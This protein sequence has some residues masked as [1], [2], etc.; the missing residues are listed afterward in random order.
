MKLLFKRDE[1]GTGFP[2]ADQVLVGELVMN[3]VTGKLYTKLT[4][5][6]IV[7]WV[8][9]KICFDPIPEITVSYENTVITSDI[10]EDY[11]CLGGIIEFEVA[12]LKPDPYKYTFEFV[13]LTTNTS[14]G[15]ISLQNPKYVEYSIPKPQSSSNETVLVRKAS[16]PVNLS[17]AN[18]KQGVS[19]FKFIVLSQTD[20]K[21]LLEKIITIKCSSQS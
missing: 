6:S 16:I 17:I 19:I 1:S 13:E 15:E 7:E 11:C 20:N 14:S 3:S 12:K 21:K 2:S 4:D 9:Q 18:G 8:A 5:G 10:I